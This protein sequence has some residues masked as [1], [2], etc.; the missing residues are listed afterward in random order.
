MKNFKLFIVLSMIILG[1]LSA[2]CDGSEFFGGEVCTQVGCSDG[3]TIRISEERPDSL[4]LTIYLNDDTEA[5][6]TTHCTNQNQH[7]ILGIDEETPENVAV[8]IGWKNGE[9]N[10]IFTPEY[11]NFQPNGPE[12]PPTCKSAFIEIDL[13]TE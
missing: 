1:F 10:K 2:G 7:C 13:S 5:F 4:S 3:V 12:C 9:F 11:E 8:K 6:A